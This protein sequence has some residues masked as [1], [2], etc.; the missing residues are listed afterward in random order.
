MEGTSTNPDRASGGW[1]EGRS[2][3]ERKE[4]GPITRMRRRLSA[5]DVAIYRMTYYRR[6]RL[7]LRKRQAASREAMG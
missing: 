2:D 3:M 7:N 4:V 5:R 1:S 6:R